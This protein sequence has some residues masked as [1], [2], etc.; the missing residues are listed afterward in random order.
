MVEFDP[1]VSLVCIW[2]L[3]GFFFF[4][5][6]KSYDSSIGLELGLKVSGAI[7]VE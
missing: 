5:R 3:Q 4:I 1:N 7:Q 6:W 2:H